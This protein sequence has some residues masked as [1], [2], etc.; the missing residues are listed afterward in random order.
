M[1]SLWR[2]S[3]GKL[4]PTVLITFTAVIPIHK[5]LCLPPTCYALICKNTPCVEVQCD[6]CI[7]MSQAL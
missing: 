7:Y 5:N 3:S 1:N 2:T 4:I 6:A